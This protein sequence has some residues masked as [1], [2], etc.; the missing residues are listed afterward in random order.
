MEHG[1]QQ[2]KMNSAYKILFLLENKEI[3]IVEV[4]RTDLADAPK[5]QKYHWI[6]YD[7]AGGSVEKLSFVSMNSSENFQERAFIQGKL[8]FNNSEGVFEGD[9]KQFVLQNR[10]G[11][12]LQDTVFR[13][14]CQ[15]LDLKSIHQ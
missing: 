6:F 8:K 4:K 3:I 1:N 15:Y 13:H 2:E 9:G 5:D 12:S 11:N 14:I 7:K 10:T